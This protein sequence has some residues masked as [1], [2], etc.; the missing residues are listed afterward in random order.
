MNKIPKLRAFLQET[1]RICGSATVGGQR[2]INFDGCKIKTSDGKI[3]Y[4]GN[5]IILDGPIRTSRTGP[6]N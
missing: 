1:L 3:C 5:K 6:K 4:I 2:R